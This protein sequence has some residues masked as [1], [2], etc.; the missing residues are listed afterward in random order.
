MSI[1]AVWGADKE[2]PFQAKPVTSYANRQTTEKVT[3]AVDPFGTED[4]A[5]EAFGKLNPNQYGILPVL[6]VIQNDGTASLSLEDLRV[7]YI[8]SARQRIE[9]TPATDVPRTMGPKRPGPDPDRFPSPL[10]RI[11]GNKN[12]LSAWEIAGR[13]FSAKVLPPGESAS[14]FFYF[15]AP[16][17]PGATVY[18]TGMR[19]LPS[20]RELFYFEI[21]LG[22]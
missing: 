5:R 8:T 20:R 17:R 19:E 22:P 9:A 12:P 13:A 6:V 1:V 2:K 18:L 16:N 14:G 15:Q 11:G 10:P 4:K 3:V 21:P 7:E